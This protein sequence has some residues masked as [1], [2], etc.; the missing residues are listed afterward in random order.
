MP[1]P[2]AGPGGA[3]MAALDWM[4]DQN[5]AAIAYDDPSV[6]SF[7]KPGG[8]GPMTD[9]EKKAAAMSDA[10]NWLREQDEGTDGLDDPDALAK[11]LSKEADGFGA[12]LSSEAQRAQD[13]S[14]A[15]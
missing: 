11:M 6:A 2:A 5:A 15:L 4:R 10:L 12:P 14:N 3:E 1:I 8:G 13:M 7:G 9:E